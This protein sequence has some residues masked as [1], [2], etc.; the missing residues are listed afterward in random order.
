MDIRVLII[1]S[2]AVIVPNYANLV[3]WRRTRKM[4][5]KKKDLDRDSGLSEM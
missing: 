4:A 3:H 5:T 2:I 1:K